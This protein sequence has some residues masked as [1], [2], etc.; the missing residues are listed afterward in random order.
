MS[1]Q[2]CDPIISPALSG[3]PLEVG[4]KAF[5]QATEKTSSEVAALQ[6]QVAQLTTLLQALIPA[7]AASAPVETEAP[8]T[9]TKT[10]TK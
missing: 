5:E 9:E 2:L 10:K 1:N 8:A 6:A 4:Q 7:P 3:V